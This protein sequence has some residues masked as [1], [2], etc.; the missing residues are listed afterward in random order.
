MN[1]Y[2]SENIAFLIKKNDLAIDDFGN[3]FDLTRGVT[4]QYIRKSTLPK[5]IT[6]QKICAHYKISIDDF[7]NKDLSK[8]QFT[9]RF[10]TNSIGKSAPKAYGIK[11][12]QLLY[13]NEPED[14]NEFISPRYVASL[15]KTIEDKEEII[16]MLKEKLQL[17]EKSRT[18]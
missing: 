8:E 5:I 13:T 3:L 6:I 18:A 10:H 1:N 17:D 14:E 2:I 16:K 9:Y 15:E 4:G 7:V 11:Q 12:G